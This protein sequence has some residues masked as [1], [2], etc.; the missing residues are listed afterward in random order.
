MANSG[1]PLQKCLDVLQAFV[2]LA[3]A[4]PTRQLVRAADLDAEGMAVVDSF[5]AQRLIISDTH[6]GT[7]IFAIGHEAL[8]RRWDQMHNHITTN[9]SQLR[10][11]TELNTLAAAWTRSG[12][13]PAYLIEGRRLRDINSATHTLYLPADASEFLG[14]SQRYDQDSREARADAISRQALAMLVSDPALA[15]AL[16]YACYSELAPTALA[17][18]ALHSAIP[19]TDRIVWSAMG[20]V[21]AIAFAPDGRLAT[22]SK[23]GTVKIWD[24]QG[25]LVHTLTGHTE[26]VTSVAFANDGRLATGSEDKTVKIWDEQ[27]QRLLDLAYRTG[28]VA[29]VAFASDGRLA[30]GSRDGT[31][32]VWDQQGQRLQKLTGHTRSVTAV[33]FAPDG[34]LATSSSQGTKFLGRLRNAVDGLAISSEDGV[35]KIWSPHGLLLHTLIERNVVAVSVAF[36]SDGRLATGSKD[37][38]VKIWDQQG[39]RLQDLTGHTGSVTAV[40]FTPDGRLAIGCQ[41]GTVTVWDQQ[42]CLVHTLTGHTASVTAVAFASDGRLA[43]GSEDG[44]VKV[45]GTSVELLAVLCGAPPLQPH[46]A[47]HSDAETDE[48]TMP[49]GQVSEGHSLGR[50]VLRLFAISS[51]AL[52]SD[53]RLAAGAANGL[54]LIW[55]QDGQLLH[56]LSYHHE[57]VVSVAFA[58]DGR[59]ATGSANGLVLIWDRCGQLLHTLTGQG[60]RVAFAPDGRL[61]TSGHDNTIRIWDRQH[62]LLHTLASGNSLGAVAFAHDGRVAIGA[63]DGTVRIWDRHGRLLRNLSGHN[64]PAYSVAFAV[65]GRLASGSAD[66]TVKIWDQEGQLLLTLTGPSSRVQWVAWAP[67]GRLA[68]GAGDGMVKIWNLP[69]GDDALVAQANAHLSVNLTGLQRSALGLTATL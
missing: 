39:Q 68:V 38:T 24:Q 26:R 29:S 48:V 44:T 52:A 9:A 33:A 15:L 58:S 47:V 6:Q 23:D 19:A 59:L 67:D 66:K 13:D 51:V 64:G 2:S 1:L 21:Y 42:G 35:V 22:S 10:K 34:R 7:N 20:P 53:G 31:V 8:L 50:Q 65:D 55:D 36:A 5:M 56:T 4:E 57:G 17:R 37:K 63:L 45:W 40:A 62:G 43:T 16:A 60:N 69:L 49:S 3:D 18:Y 11:L 54:V 28:S 61:A 30:I 32:T 12:R 25:C 41:D 14:V 27:G 46:S